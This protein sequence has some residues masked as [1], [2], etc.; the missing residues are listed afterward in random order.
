M[1]EKLIMFGIILNAI[2]HLQ[3][4]SA[5]NGCRSKYTIGCEELQYN[6]EQCW[7][8]K[9]AEIY[10]FCCELA[11]VQEVPCLVCPLSRG[12]STKRVVVI[13]CWLGSEVQEDCTVNLRASQTNNVDDEDC[14]L[15]HLIKATPPI[16]PEEKE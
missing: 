11:Q 5:W 14:L 15:D 8:A 6:F 7:Q 13:G 3:S 9:T 12:C 2:F 1:N 4:E 10:I 16:K